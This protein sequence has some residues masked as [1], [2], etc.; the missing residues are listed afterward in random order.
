MRAGLGDAVFDAAYA[1]GS[2]LTVEQAAAVALAVE[3]PDLAAGSKRF[4]PAVSG[5]PIRVFVCLSTSGPA[6]RRARVSGTARR[7]GVAGAG[8]LARRGVAAA[9]RGAAGVRCW[10]ASPARRAASGS[11]GSR[12]GPAHGR[13]GGGDRAARARRAGTGAGAARRDLRPG[14]PTAGTGPGRVRY[15]VPADPA[16]AAFLWQAKDVRVRL[17]LAGWSVDKTWAGDGPDESTP[18]RAAGV[19]AAH[20]AGRRTAVPRRQGRLA[21]DLHRRPRRRGTPGHRAGR[22]DVGTDRRA[23]RAACSARPSA[24]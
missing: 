4:T 12:A 20:G 11:G 21:G 7:A 22:A 23:G 1:E 10:S 17:D 9:R 16:S 8:P 3:H 6:G 14:Q 15:T 24:G 18:S 2:A 5:R 13:G 19:G